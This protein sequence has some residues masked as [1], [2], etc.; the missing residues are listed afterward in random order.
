MPHVRRAACNLACKSFTNTLDFFCE[1]SSARRGYCAN[2]MPAP[3][4][5]VG[6]HCVEWVASGDYAELAPWLHKSAPAARLQ[7]KHPAPPGCAFRRF[8]AAEAAALLAGKRTL[9]LGDS[10]VH[11]LHLSLATYV[12]SGDSLSQWDS[13]ARGHQHPLVERWWAPNGGHNLK[14]SQERWFALWNGYLNATHMDLGED[15]MCD[16]FRAPPVNDTQPHH[17]SWVHNRHVRFRASATGSPTGSLSLV[18]WMGDST[19]PRW[20]ATDLNK[21][22]LACTS[23]EECGRQPFEVNFNTNEHATWDLERQLNTVLAYFEPDYVMV[24]IHNHWSPPGNE[25]YMY[26]HCD[27]PRTF[28]PSN[29]A[30]RKARYVWRTSSIASWSPES[31]SQDHHARAQ[32]AQTHRANELPWC[33][34]IGHMHGNENDTHKARPSRVPVYADMEALSTML[35]TDRGLH[36][37]GLNTSTIFVDCVRAF[38]PFVCLAYPRCNPAD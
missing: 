21:W 20:H 4:P 28:K 6:P 16:C 3:A 1:I 17:P 12:H 33:R 19:L 8:T 30:A 5:I 13:A 22:T 18:A 35:M 7:L 2:E 29:A 24:G 9:F 11:Y 10:L 15:D 32:A 27:F 38:L 25:S 23:V 37:L 36:K 34:R 14:M 26:H 31:V